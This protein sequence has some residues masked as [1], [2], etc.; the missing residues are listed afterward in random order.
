M[1]EYRPWVRSE[2]LAELGGK[3]AR[4]SATPTW[5][6]LP[7]GPTRISVGLLA[8][9]LAL[10][11]PILAVHAG[12]GSSSAL[13]SAQANALTVTVSPPVP[14]CTQDSSGD[15]ET[16]ST[17]DTSDTSKACDVAGPDSDTSQESSEPSSSTAPGSGS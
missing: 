17:S 12:V 8:L 13:F 3:D 16:P 15:S 4:A 11:A 9:L 6:R 10:A 5:R 7:W 1:A 2:S 14:V